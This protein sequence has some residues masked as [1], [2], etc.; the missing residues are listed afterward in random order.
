MKLCIFGNCQL[1]SVGFLIDHA[2]KQHGLDIEVLWYKPIY[3]MTDDDYMPFFAAM[4]AADAI[5]CQYHDEKWGI[6]ST[7]NLRKY[8]D[9]KIVPT[10]ESFVSSPQVGGWEKGPAR[11]YNMYFMDYRILH[12]YLDGVPYDQVEAR[13][14]DAAP[15]AGVI[16]EMIGETVAKYR[17]YHDSGMVVFDYSEQYRK[18]IA[19]D[20]DCFFLHNHPKNAQLEWMTNQIL[21]AAGCPKQLSLA[22]ISEILFDFQAPSL[23]GPERKPYFIRPSVSSITS[24]ARLYYAYFET[25]DRKMLKRELSASTYARVF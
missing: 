1:R 14:F 11:F 8:F 9:L 22:N 20:L 10:L 25:V 15:R 18:A 6:W 21:G 24:A 12:L 16:A 23:T 5:Y 2:A 19:E 7:P 13:Y 3:Q 17:R 4:E